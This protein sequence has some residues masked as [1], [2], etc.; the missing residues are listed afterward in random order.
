MIKLNSCSA[1]KS[2]Q[3]KKRQILELSLFYYVTLGVVDTTH[4][5]REA[6][7]PCKIL[8]H[9]YQTALHHISEDNNLDIHCDEKLESQR[10]LF[11]G[12]DD[13]AEQFV[14]GFKFDCVKEVIIR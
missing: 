12:K 1:G 11:T 4:F 13:K 3:G 2:S 10:T 8:V 5:C 14:F 6:E 7:S 9:I